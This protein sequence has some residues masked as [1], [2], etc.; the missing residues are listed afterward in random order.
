[1]GWPGRHQRLF[2]A[3]ARQH[4]C[5]GPAG[6]VAFARGAANRLFAPLHDSRHRGGRAGGRRALHALGPAAGPPHRPQ[7]R[8]GDAAGAGHARH[9]RDRAVRAPPPFSK[10]GG[11]GSTSTPRPTSPGRSASARCWSAACSSS[12]CTG[13]RLGPAAVSAGGLAR[14]TGRGGAGAD[15]L[16]SAVGHPARSDRGPRGPGDHP[17]HADCPGR[18]A[19]ADTR[20]SARWW[21]AARCIT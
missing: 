18:A 21:S 5:P 13:G 15:Q 2:R 10:P 11:R 3:D 12:F 6:V 1:M 9:V 14:L 17:D 16:H 7:R 8:Y 19:T 4:R 20:R